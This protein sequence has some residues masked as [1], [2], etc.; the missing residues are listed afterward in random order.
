MDLN[1]ISGSN[2]T[3]ET[4]RCHL[5][6]VVRGLCDMCSGLFFWKI[7]VIYSLLIFKVTNHIHKFIGTITALLTQIHIIIKRTKLVFT[8][9]TV[10]LLFP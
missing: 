1:Y 5:G 9:L 10:Q 8:H 3:D 2:A 6:K 7:R 4:S